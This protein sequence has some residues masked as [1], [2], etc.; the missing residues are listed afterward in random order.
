MDSRILTVHNGTHQISIPTAFVKQLGWFPGQKLI[1]ELAND[2][3]YLIIGSP[4]S[5]LKSGDLHGS[6]G[7]PA[8]LR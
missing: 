6:K 4:D 5:M 8:V 7:P 3:K 1:L 2:Q